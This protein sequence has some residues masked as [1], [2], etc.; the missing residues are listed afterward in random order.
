MGEDSRVP[1]LSRRVPGATD[2]DRPKPVPR[3]PPRKLPEALLRRMQA[4]ID[5]A[6]ERAS[7]QEQAACP[8]R[9]AAL[10][11][12]PPGASGGPKPSAQVARQVLS[13]S[14]AARISEPEDLT[15]PIPIVSGSASSDILSPAV[16]EISAQLELAAEPEL[17]VAAEPAVE[18][19][20]EP[21]V[22]PELAKDT[23]ADHERDA[24][25]W[26]LAVRMTQQQASRRKAAGRRYRI[27]GMVVSV[28]I[29]VTVSLAFALSRHAPS[30]PGEAG[31]ADM[32]Q[33]LAAAWVA[34]QVS[35]TA[36]VSCDPVMCRVL[37]GHGI[38]ADDLLE[39]RQGTVD[40]L[41]SDVIVATA[42][43]RSQFGGNLSS[44]YAPTVIAS[45]GSGNARID[46]RTIAPHG[47]AAYRSALSADLQARKTSGTVLLGNNRIVVSRAARKQLSAGQVDSRLLVT[48]VGLA[49]QQPVYI[50]TFGDSAP[51]AG[52]GIP[53][54]SA[55][56]AEAKDLPHLSNSAYMHSML[57]LLRQQRGRYRPAS[58]KQARLAGGVPVLR[59][60]FAAPSPLG[61]IGPTTP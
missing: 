53:L 25:A 6:P 2:S 51:G 15:Q 41:R 49:T 42:A 32:T 50:V 58:V 20:P 16:E 14:L 47:A 19:E 31:S 37:Q 57:A 11:R 29:L 28:I 56:L 38:P 7:A 10:P 27:A 4:A 12:R 36:T 5:A 24:A 8:E 35:R 34:G 9:P 23:P 45:F 40:L 46:I 59:I 61:L 55:E 3:V 60:E 18:A 33:D 30:A 48:I 13:A 52:A 44:V 26:A 21:A 43:V 54:R 22:Q 17:A 39:L 1:P